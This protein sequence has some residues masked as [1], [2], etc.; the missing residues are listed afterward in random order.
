MAS[1]GGRKPKQRVEDA[2]ALFAPFEPAKPARDPAPHYH[3]HRT[4]LR[5]RFEDTGADALADYEL[6]ELLLFRVIPR[7]D[8]KP[9]AKALIARFGDFAAVLAADPRRLVE[10]D[11]CGPSVAQE[12]KTIQAAVERAARIEA[13]RKP[14]VGSWTKLIDY[15][16]VTLQHETREQFRV[17]FLDV[18]NHILA[19]EV[20]GEGTLDHAPVY[21]REVVRRALEL[22]AASMIL[23]HNHPSGDP[24]PSRADAEITREIVA[25][26]DTLGVKVHDHLVIGRHGA[27]SLRQL[28]LM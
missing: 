8:T 16:R 27:A 25:A 10:V 13:K 22:R 4:R 6:L 28:G 26:A 24:T 2:G 9:L 18:K 23:V 14:V 15:C 12:L 11:G 21:P 19:D 17:L 7:R 5:K 1:G 3:E 20:L